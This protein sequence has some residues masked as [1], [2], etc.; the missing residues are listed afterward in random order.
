MKV[1]RLPGHPDGY[2]NNAAQ[3]A[4]RPYGVGIVQV[5]K[6]CPPLRSCWWPLDQ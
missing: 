2:V 3:A 6:I 4:P 1:T 5:A